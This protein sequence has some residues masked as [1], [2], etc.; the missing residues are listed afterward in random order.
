MY[1]GVWW[2]FSVLCSTQITCRS[3]LRLTNLSAQYCSTAA[4]C[5][6]SPSATNVCRSSSPSQHTCTC[7]P[8]LMTAGILY[9][10]IC[11][12]PCCQKQHLYCWPCCHINTSAAQL[13]L[14]LLPHLHFAAQLSFNTTAFPF[15]IRL[16]PQDAPYCTSST[17]VHIAA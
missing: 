6:H 14:A 3:R 1:D 15:I 7:S 8:V 11:C 9:Q 17:V 10:H 2:S 16:L 5:Q 12:W 13:L 4:I